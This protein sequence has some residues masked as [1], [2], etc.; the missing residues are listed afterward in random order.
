MRKI[1]NILL[2][3]FA[4]VLFGGL[5]N[6]NAEGK[7]KVYVFEA[8]GCPYCEAEIEYLQGLSSYNEK[9]EIIRK[10]LYVDHVDWKWGQDYQLGKAVAEAF[11]SIGNSNATY[12]AT[13]FVVI[14]D[15]YASTGYSTNLESYIDA[16]YEAGDKDVVGCY[17]NGGTSCLTGA[18]TSIVVDP[19]TSE[20]KDDSKDVDTITT[21]ILVLI[22][23]G[24]VALVVYTGKKNA[25]SKVENIKVEEKPVVKEV[26]KKVSTAKKTPKSNTK[27]ASTKKKK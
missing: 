14:S 23:A 18:D 3:V 6:V 27:K 24:T 25:E 5:T 4:F 1:K 22:I 19:S 17:A 10:E 11:Q 9:F 26:E 16:A 2:L 15:V 20:S 12:D 8:G 13:P 21:I 7:V